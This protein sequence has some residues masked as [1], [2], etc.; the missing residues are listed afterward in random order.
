VNGEEDTA[1]CSGQDMMF[2]SGLNL[3][4]EAAQRI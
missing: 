3:V 4:G 1:W 2:L